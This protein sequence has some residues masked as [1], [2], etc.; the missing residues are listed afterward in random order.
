[1]DTVLPTRRFQREQGLTK[2][3]SCAP[4]EHAARAEKLLQAQKSA[5]KDV[6]NL[7]KELAGYIAADLIAKAAA[8]PGSVVVYHRKEAGADLAFLQTLLSLLGDAARTSVFVLAASDA[9]GKDGMFVLAGPPAFVA[10]H[11]RD[12][13]PVIA[14]KGGGGKNNGIMQGKATNLCELDAL[15]AELE[16]RLTVADAQ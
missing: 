12:V 14:G 6:K 3:L 8:T 15:A 4:D 9:R 16:R 2:V 13:L 1:M 7:Q 10:A 11:G 5:A